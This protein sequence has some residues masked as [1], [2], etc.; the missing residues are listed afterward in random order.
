MKLV[1]SE[2]KDYFSN[3]LLTS[4]FIHNHIS[5]VKLFKDKYCNFQVD[6]VKAAVHGKCKQHQCI[7]RQV[8]R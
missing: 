8:K 5:F 4:D 1:V 7:H 3:I 6:V 2:I